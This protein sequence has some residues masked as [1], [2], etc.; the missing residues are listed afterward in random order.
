MKNKLGK[1]KVQTLFNI[2]VL[3]FDIILTACLTLLVIWQGWAVTDKFLSRPQK[4]SISYKGLEDIPPIA[5]SVCYVLNVT[6]CSSTSTVLGNMFNDYSYHDIA[7]EEC[8]WKEGGIGSYANSS[9]AFWDEVGKE[10]VHIEKLV[11][12]IEVWDTSNHSWQ[13][14]LTHT[15]T[16]I[17][18][19]VWPFG[20]SEVQICNT[21]TNPLISQPRYLRIIP[22]QMERKNKKLLY[23]HSVGQFLGPVFKQDLFLLEHLDYKYSN[24]FYE[25]NLQN[26]KSIS[27]EENPCDFN[28]NTFDSCVRAIATE[29][30]LNKSGCLPP[31]LDVGDVDVSCCLNNSAGSYA[32]D[33]FLTET[34]AAK[35]RCLPP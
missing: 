1:D 24:V 10:P 2:S 9:K 17:N 18:R 3:I 27:T 21:F 34:D 28:W 23:F 19:T 32:F 6:D 7:H 12:K 25:V 14:V 31:F 8:A 35:R 15:N 13:N 26:I 29:N 4:I 20:F 16:S 5:I 11:D 30:T 33:T 22:S